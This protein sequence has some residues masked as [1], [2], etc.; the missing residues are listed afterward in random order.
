MNS[1]KSAPARSIA[2]RS[3]L[4]SLGACTALLACAGGSANN[5]DFCSVKVL[6][7]ES[8]SNRPGATDLAYR[9]Q[10]D[11]GSP[12]VVS[13]VAKLGADNFVTGK[14]VEVGP[15]PFTAI[16]DL[17]LT[18]MPPELLILLEVEGGKRCRAKASLPR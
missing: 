14:G 13:L 10:G 6:G 8:F 7:V 11:A 12:A 1:P 16:V 9:V 4:A 5:P 3:A 18:G 15:G 2:T 17:K